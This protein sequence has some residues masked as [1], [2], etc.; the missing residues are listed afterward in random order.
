MG[1]FQHGRLFIQTLHSYF[2]RPDD[3]LPGR[4]IVTPKQKKKH[5]F[6]IVPNCP[7]PTEPREYSS[8]KHWRIQSFTADF[9]V[10]SY[11]NE[12]QQLHVIKN[13][14]QFMR[15]TALKLQHCTGKPNSAFLQTTQLK[16]LLLTPRLHGVVGVTRKMVLLPF[17]YDIILK[18]TC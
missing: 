7:R 10:C 16:I 1:I 8:S 4:F 12:F 9:V 11:Q 6:C 15:D 2:Q 18:P 3:F 17:K 14:L 13:L 5:A